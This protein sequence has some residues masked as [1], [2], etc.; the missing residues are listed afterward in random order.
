MMDGVLAEEY[1]S[2]WA[3]NKNGGDGHSA[4]P[5]YQIVGD[6]QDWIK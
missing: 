3:W 5:T 6:L 1:A 2:R 4:N